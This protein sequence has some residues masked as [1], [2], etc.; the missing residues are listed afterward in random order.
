MPTKSY[1]FSELVNLT[2]NREKTSFLNVPKKTD[3]PS[4]LHKCGTKHKKLAHRFLGIATC[5]T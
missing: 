4:P 2:R 5:Y 3:F 1:F